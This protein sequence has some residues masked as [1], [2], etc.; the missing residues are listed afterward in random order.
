MITAGSSGDSEKRGACSSAGRAASSCVPP[1]ATKATKATRD[2]GRHRDRA[3]V[4]AALGR[5]ARRDRDEQQR[6]DVVDDRG[7]E[8]RAATCGARGRR[9]W[10]STA[11]VM[12]TLVAT[13]A[14][15]MNSEVPVL[16]PSVGT[17]SRRRRRTGATTPSSADRHGSCAHL[18]Q[19]GQA[20]L[21]PD[22]E[23]QWDDAQLGEDLDKLAGL[24]EAKDGRAD[25]QAREDLAD[26]RRLAQAAKQ[27]VAELRGEQHDEQVRQDVRDA[28]GS[29]NGHGGAFSG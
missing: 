22:P 20:R 1:S 25:Q 2:R 21:Q 24:D 6:Q 14:A 9:V 3:D 7:A 27:L 8:D 28:G 12:P 5:H 15:P 19:I 10:M 16:S 23:Q 29:G 17:E 13:S 26:E 18:A 11:D 4:D